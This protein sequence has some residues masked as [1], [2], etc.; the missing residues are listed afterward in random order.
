MS[1]WRSLVACVLLAA[2]ASGCTSFW[3][4]IREQERGHAAKN[5]EMRIARGDCRG[6]MRSL[7]R[8]QA[9]AELGSY[10]TESTLTKA[11]CLDRI[12]EREQSRAH[13]RLLRDFY[14]AFRPERIA[15][16]FGEKDESLELALGEAPALGG[17][18][19]L[20]LGEPRYS[21]SADRSQLGGP[22]LVRFWVAEDG[23]IRDVRVLEM[24]HPLLASWAI[25]AVVKSKLEKG[26]FVELPRA[27]VTRFVFQTRAPRSEPTATD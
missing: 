15:K 23:S 16:E 5:A 14:P 4:S 26:A 2:L 19:A 12:G 25:E 9:S 13:Y 24:P 3:A 18:H 6:A 27:V 8:A 7:E 20:D 22:V 10:A 21:P 11:Q 1:R 17:L